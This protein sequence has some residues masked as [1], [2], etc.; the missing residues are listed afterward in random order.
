MS[1]GSSQQARTCLSKF[2][3]LSCDL[4][5]QKMGVSFDA[6]GASSASD[7]HSCVCVCV[8]VCAISFPEFLFRE[9]LDTVKPASGFLRTTFPPSALPWMGRHWSLTMGLGQRNDILGVSVEL[10]RILKDACLPSL[11][12]RLECNLHGRNVFLGQGIC[13]TASH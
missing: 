7:P 6:G 12:S 10:P 8:C 9:W 3:F 4:P 5:G 13:N 2:L 11:P 1:R